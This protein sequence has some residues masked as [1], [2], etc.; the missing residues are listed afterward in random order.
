VKRA[1]RAGGER[2]ARRA[3]A[4]AGECLRPPRN[5]HRGRSL[6]RRR[7]TSEPGH[8]RRSG[9]T[10]TFPL[11]IWSATRNGLPRKVDVLGTLILTC[12]LIVVAT[13]AVLTRCGNRE[14]P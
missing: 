5:D 11:W 13:S 3:Q 7:A 10:Q 12:G 4:A 9:S 14:P 8:S 2:G 1:A 6:Q